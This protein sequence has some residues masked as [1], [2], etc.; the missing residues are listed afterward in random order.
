MTLTA[1]KELE[2]MERGERYFHIQSLNSVRKVPHQ[3]LLGLE[4]FVLE[5]ANTSLL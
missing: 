4:H 5:F 3:C 1:I 2:E